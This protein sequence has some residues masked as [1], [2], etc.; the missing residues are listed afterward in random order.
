MKIKVEQPR[1]RAK[2]IKVRVV[3]KWAEY[4]EH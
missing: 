1:S 2:R 4:I 3:S